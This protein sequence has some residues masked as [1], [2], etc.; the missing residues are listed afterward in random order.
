MA[1]KL[2]AV[3]NEAAADDVAAVSAPATSRKRSTTKLGLACIL[4]DAATGEPFALP[5]GIKLVAFRVTRDI[6]ALQDELLAGGLN[7]SLYLK[8]EVPAAA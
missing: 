4:V 3:Q 2:T 6:V 5:P 7:A 1:T 8:I